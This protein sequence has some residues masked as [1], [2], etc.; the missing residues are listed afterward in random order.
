MDGLL[1]LVAATEFDET[2]SRYTVAEG[3]KFNLELAETPGST[4]HNP[5]LIEALL[6]GS[7]TDLRATYALPLL[8]NVS[9]ERTLGVR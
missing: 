5:F 6:I 1:A 9:L 7:I 4:I 2:D 8:T 3:S